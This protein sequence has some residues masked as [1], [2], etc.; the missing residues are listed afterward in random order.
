MSTPLRL[1]PNDSKSS[2]ESGFSWV[3]FRMNGVP[4]DAL[5]S[6]KINTEKYSKMMIFAFTTIMFIIHD[7]IISLLQIR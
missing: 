6:D 4:G 1:N 3:C 2:A 7:E 5:E